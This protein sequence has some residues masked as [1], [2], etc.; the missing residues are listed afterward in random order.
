MSN[1]SEL[2][3]ENPDLTDKPD[4]PELECNLANPPSCEFRDVCFHYPTQVLNQL[5]LDA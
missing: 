4:A 2:L 3:A 1:L 5:E